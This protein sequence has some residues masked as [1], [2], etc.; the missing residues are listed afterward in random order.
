MKAQET[1]KRY[2]INLRGPRIST[3]FI[4]NK[5]ITLKLEKNKTN[6]YI[7]KRRFKQCVYL[8]LNIPIDKIT[9]LEDVVSVD[10][11]ESK[12]K[13]N[14]K[15]FT[16]EEIPPKFLFWAHCSNMQV[17]AENNYNTRLLHR[18]IAFPLLKQLAFRGDPI[19]RKVF[20]T[21]II[22]RLESNYLP[23]TE[24]LI[25][26]GYFDNFSE[27]EIRSLFCREDLGLIEHYLEIIKR[28]E[29]LKIEDLN[30]MR[31]IPNEA[32]KEDLIDR[33]FLSYKTKDDIIIFESNNYETS[34][35]IKNFAEFLS[36]EQKDYLFKKIKNLF[37]HSVEQEIKKK[38]AQVL[39]EIESNFPSIIGEIIE[40]S[41]VRD[42]H[43]I[44]RSHIYLSN[45][46]WDQVINKVGFQFYEELFSII[47]NQNQNQFDYRAFDLLLQFGQKGVL[48]IQQKLKSLNEK[49]KSEFLFNIISFYN[50]ED[51]SFFYDIIDGL[52]EVT[53][54]N[55]V[56]N[57][58]LILEHRWKILESW[59]NDSIFDFLKDLKQHKHPLSKNKFKSEILQLLEIKNGMI[60]IELYHRGFL[61]FLEK[62]E[63]IRLFEN[64]DLNNIVNDF[65]EYSRN[66]EMTIW[67]IVTK[68]GELGDFGLRFMLKILKGDLDYN[69]WQDKDR[70]T[71]SIEE[72]VKNDPEHAKKE[73]INFIIEG[74][75]DDIRELFDHE[76]IKLLNKD[77]VLE[78][79]HNPDAKILEKLNN[80]TKEEHPP[81]YIENFLSKIGQ[82]GADIIF[83]LTQNRE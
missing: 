25:I 38:K 59:F 11:A 28:N 80:A 33:L 13:L 48:A 41:F 81:R 70:I 46:V 49:E 51:D 67:W 45:Q 62:S 7:K 42:L 14:D 53:S 50:E 20:K 64:F 68:V 54:N 65:L 23:V 83:R 8:K 9:V 4:I 40:E 71:K 6:I 43:K 69:D 75:Y 39:R 82:K 73:I 3:I 44:L 1:L 24:Y 35:L 2:K 5:Y 12:A 36:I 34:K 21:E 66:N 56:M 27:D 57:L 74:S 22:K 76:V 37:L 63:I 30:L 61:S 60:D 15:A 18:D 58:L 26:N 16:I 47:N 29:S 10:Q 55:L 79:Y 19:A 17:W 31:F 52:D 72:L 32:I 77:D 78:I